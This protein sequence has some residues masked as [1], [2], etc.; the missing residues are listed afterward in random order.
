[1]VSIARKNLFHDPGRLVI[2]LLGLT[3]SL[4]LILFAMGTF[5]GTLDESVT[6]VNHTDADIWVLQKGNKEI[7][8]PSIFEDIVLKD[9]ERMPEVGSAHKL[10]FSNN[11]IEKDGRK[12]GVMLV[13]FNM[14]DKVGAPW[15][16]VSGSLAGLACGNSIIVDRS[17][18]RKFGKLD[19]G[20]RFTIN[21]QAQR[22]VGI[23][24]GAKW[25]INP[26]VFTTYENAQTLSRMRPGETNFILVKTKQGS[27]PAL[28]ARKIISMGTVDAYPTPKARRN[29]RNFMIYE[30]GMGMSLGAMAIAGLIVAAIIISLTVYTA[31]MERIPEFG[32]LK[33]MGARRSDI[34]RILLG[35]V[36]I[37]VVL[38]F[39]LGALFGF[40]VSAVIGGFTILPMRITPLALVIAFSLTLVLSILGS[41]FCIR[42]V[43]KVDPAIVF[44]T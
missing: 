24:T 21:G 27:D 9:I 26:Y 14:K 22:L 8:G 42:K 16:I 17:V 11:L 33:A 40:V 29:T 3:A 32:T 5:I 6:I 20:D 19:V 41:L 28:V 23:G 43:N 39:L 10:V 12:M 13:G 35:Q 31:T 1:M 37:S 25:F 44:R 7:L 2:T 15:D 36:V 34:Y 38:G 18:E 30:S 4:V